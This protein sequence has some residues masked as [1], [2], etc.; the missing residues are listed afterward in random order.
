MSSRETVNTAK[1][2]NEQRQ[3]GTKLI[4]KVFFTMAGMSTVMTLNC[5]FSI[6]NFWTDRYG[7]GTLMNTI[8]WM[9]VG[10]LLGLLFYALF[11][12]MM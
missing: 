6:N 8:F 4:S 12:E 5:L 9:N 10:G 2:R 11:K 1:R 7:Q 3:K